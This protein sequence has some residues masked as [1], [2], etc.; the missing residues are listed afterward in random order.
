M[1][2]TTDRQV[3][4]GNEYMLMDSFARENIGKMKGRIDGNLAFGVEYTMGVYPNPSGS[5]MISDND[6]KTTDYI[7][8]EPETSYYHNSEYPF[9]HFY[10]EPDAAHFISGQ[11]IQDKLFTTPENAHYIRVGGKKEYDTFELY[12]GETLV[13]LLDGVTLYDNTLVHYGTVSTNNDYVSTDYIPVS[14]PIRIIV[15]AGEDGAPY[16]FNG[17]N[18][19]KTFNGGAVAYTTQYVNNNSGQIAYIRLSFS[20]EWKDTIKIYGVFVADEPYGYNADRFLAEYA[21]TIID[22]KIASNTQKEFHVGSDQE[23][24]TLRAGIAAA[25]NTNNATVYVHSG[26]YDLKQEF[27]SEIAAHTESHCGI[28][29]GNGVHV[30]FYNGAKVICNLE[31]S[32]YDATTWEWINDH[33]EPFWVEY[34][35]Q[36]N[37]IIENMVCEMKNTR[38]CVHDE[39]AGIDVQ[40]I[41]KFINCNMKYTS[42]RTSNFKYIQC[43]G[44]GLGKNGNITVEGGLYESVYTP[45]ENRNNQV[46]SYHNANNENAYSHIELRNIYAKGR[47]YFAFGTLGSSTKKSPVLISGCSTELAPLKDHVSGT[48]NYELYSFCNDIRTPGHWTRENNA[49]VYVED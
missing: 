6:Y 7:K 38:Y 29:L 18:H 43:I 31:S 12:Q 28:R 46:I 1:G 8:V 17:Y 41:H 48:D 10:S 4:N 22:M 40:Y 16:F 23:Y 34:A 5:N 30:I 26:T 25:T 14:S 32:D 3:V 33:F 24:T 36:C 37:F 21:K 19:S 27:A 15:D 49:W 2:L 42:S 9:F 13:D 20:A 45:D 11:I 44:G 35:D 47:S 39:L